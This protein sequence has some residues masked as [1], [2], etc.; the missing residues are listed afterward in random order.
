MRRPTWFIPMIRRDGRWMQSQVNRE[1]V[2]SLTSRVPLLPLKWCLSP[3]SG[4]RVPRLSLPGPSQERILHSGLRSRCRTAPNSPCPCP[5][6][7]QRKKNSSPS[8]TQRG[9]LRHRKCVDG[10]DEEIYRKYSEELIRF[11]TGL[12]GPDDAPDV[13]SAAVLRCLTSPAWSEV[14]E[15]KPYL[16]RSI[17][18]EAT[19]FR[20]SSS[21]RSSLEQ[22]RST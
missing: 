21:R 11:A 14:T 22:R 6:K 10:A 13:V 1:N 2:P 20:R 3:E 9:V 8:V 15:K 4:K 19:M 16:Y 12:I 7:G 5:P 17:Y 18:N